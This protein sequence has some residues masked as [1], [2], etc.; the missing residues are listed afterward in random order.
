LRIAVTCARHL[1][2][3]TGPA[4]H[5]RNRNSADPNSGAPGA[6]RGPSR[7]GG[8]GP[9]ADKEKIAAPKTAAPWQGRGRRGR[10]R[11][12]SQAQR[13]NRLKV[14]CWLFRHRHWKFWSTTRQGRSGCL[15]AKSRFAFVPG[16]RHHRA[17]AVLPSRRLRIV[18]SVTAV[19]STTFP[20]RGF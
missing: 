13:L 7:P 4:R 1:A 5:D 8:R 18:Y 2:N 17:A 12:N 14:A 20:V 15:F 10:P 3:A 16:V 6:G 19:G 9:P 11:C